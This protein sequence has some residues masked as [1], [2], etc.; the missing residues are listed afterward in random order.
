MTVQQRQFWLIIPENQEMKTITVK[1]RLSGFFNY[2][3]SLF[4]AHISTNNFITH[5]EDPKHNDA[6]MI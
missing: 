3:D 1:P 6:H 2:L 5:I 4:W